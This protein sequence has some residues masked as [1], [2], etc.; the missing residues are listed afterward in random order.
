MNIK[1]FHA[2]DISFLVFFNLIKFDLELL[3]SQLKHYL[4]AE[5]NAKDFQSCAYLLNDKWEG[6][7]KIV[8]I[9]FLPK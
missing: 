8:F 6:W 5:N 7:D 2:T 3:T 1:N 9:F 4:N